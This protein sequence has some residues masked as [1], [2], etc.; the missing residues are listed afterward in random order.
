MALFL[1]LWLGLAAGLAP[2]AAHAHR[3]FADPVPLDEYWQRLDALADA[4]A[5]A[6]PDAEAV[7]VLTDSLAA[8]EAVVLPDGQ[9]LPVDNRE[10]IALVR[11]GDLGQEGLAA[12][13]GRLAALRRARD[14]V[15]GQPAMTTGQ[16]FASLERVLSRPEFAQATPP[17]P[18]RSPLA[19]VIDRL[20]WELARW[21]RR[22][23]EVPGIAYLLTA[24][25]VAGVLAVLAYVFRGTWHQWVAEGGDKRAAV[26]D[27]GLSSKAALERAQ[28]LAT[29]G[30][31]RQAARYLYL[32]TLL[33]LDE[34]RLLRYDP[35]LTNREFLCQV[36]GDAGQAGLREALTPVV[37]LFERVWYGFAPLDG[38]GYAAY[39]R[40]VERVQQVTQRK[41]G[42]E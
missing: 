5:G 16:T 38:S 14:A 15:S 8:V 11:R 18:P 42:G 29:G 27:T 36:A 20:G 13:Q 32:S 25:G 4:L 9:V 33:W 39:A 17:T 21:L 34:R 6:E 10:L 19:Q 3:L 1:V 22:V 37:D 35:A 31:Y 30:D 24:L 28:A 12:L 26:T 2:R 41:D 23:G 7:L 40:Q